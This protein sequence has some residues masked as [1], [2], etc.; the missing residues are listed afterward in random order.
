[1]K[2][3]FFLF[4]YLRIATNLIGEKRMKYLDVKDEVSYW[5]SIEQINK[6]KKRKKSKVITEL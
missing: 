2:L 6:G 4:T 1:M 3:M 5:D